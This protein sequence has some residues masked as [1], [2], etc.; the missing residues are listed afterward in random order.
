[1]IQNGPRKNIAGNI[2]KN[3]WYNLMYY[4][5][6][7][8]SCAIQI[9]W[10]WLKYC[11]W[12]SQRHPYF[13]NSPVESYRDHFQH[14]LAVNHHDI[15]F[16]QKCMTVSHSVTQPIL[17]VVLIFCKCIWN[18]DLELNYVYVSRW[19]RDGGAGKWGRDTAGLLCC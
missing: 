15:H 5:K 7:P 16:H 18:D 6:L 11:I 1:M 4:R 8:V 19:G 3:R 10:K 13:Q 12:S 14:L 17:T 2:F 9:E